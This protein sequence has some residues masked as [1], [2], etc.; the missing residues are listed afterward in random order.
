MNDSVPP[1]KRID[2]V[3]HL[4]VKNHFKNLFLTC[5]RTQSTQKNLFPIVKVKTTTTHRGDEGCSARGAEW[6]CCLKLLPSK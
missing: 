4:L 1:K 6:Q 2:R 5:E 3:T